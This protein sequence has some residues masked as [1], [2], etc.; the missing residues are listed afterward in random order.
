MIPGNPVSF[1]KL[2]VQDFF[3]RDLLKLFSCA[4]EQATNL[5]HGV[6]FIKENTQQKQNKNQL[7]RKS[8][9]QPVALHIS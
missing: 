3:I 6:Q 5:E 9:Y 1:S 7:K 8:E 4:P 2:A